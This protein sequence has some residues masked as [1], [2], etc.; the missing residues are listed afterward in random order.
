MNRSS[1]FLLS[2]EKCY[3]GSLSTKIIY[4]HLRKMDFT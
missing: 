1:H 4:Q 3:S 2:N